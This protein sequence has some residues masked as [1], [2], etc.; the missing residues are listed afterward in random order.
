MIIQPSNNSRLAKRLIKFVKFLNTK[1]F[2]NN[3]KKSKLK[4]KPIIYLSFS[5]INSAVYA[6]ILSLLFT[7]LLLT[8]NSASLSIINGVLIGVLLGIIMMVI[9]TFYPKIIA[10]KISD[11]IDSELMFALED[12]LVQVKANVNL[13][14]AMINVIENDYQFVKDEF[15]AVVD[16]VESGDSMVKALRKL[17]LNTNSS[18]MKRTAWQLMNSIKSG[19]DIQLALQS[20][21]NELNIYY[22]SLIKNYTKELNVLTLIYLTL[23]VVAPTIGITVMIILSSFGG[24]VLTKEL[25]TTI[26]IV[27]GLLQPIIVG[28]INS[29]RPLIKI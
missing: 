26:I 6:I 19:S 10:N 8:Q 5:L 15:Q 23:A 14:K 18:F 4:V 28:F 7:L 25:L 16:D 11:A 27:L 21:I 9:F 17:A 3:F 12:M 22:H 29:R 13:Y 2:K 24:L 1:D 20:L